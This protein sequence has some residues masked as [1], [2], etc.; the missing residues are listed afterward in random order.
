MA[1]EIQMDDEERA[2]YRILAQAYQSLGEIDS[3]FSSVSVRDIK[4]FRSAIMQAASEQVDNIARKLMLVTIPHLSKYKLADILDGMRIHSTTLNA[5]LTEM[6][7]K[8][9]PHD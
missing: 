4:R 2:I 9:K 7:W 5:Q 1:D 3:N 6:G 8:I